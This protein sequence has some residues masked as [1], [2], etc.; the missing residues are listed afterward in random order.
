MTRQ[1]T[2]ITLSNATNRTPVTIEVPGAQKVDGETIPRRNYRC[3]GGLVSIPAPGVL[4]VW[5]VV[6]TSSTKYAD[7]K[8]TG[9]RRLLRVHE[10]IKTLK[11]QVEGKDCDIEKRWQYYELSPYQYSSFREHEV[12]AQR[13]GSGLRTLGM[14]TGDRVHLYAA[15]HPHW[16]LFAHGAAS[17]SLP[18]VTAYDTLGQEGLRHSLLQS[19]A[20]TIF[21]DPHL[22]NKLLELLQEVN[23]V[24]IIVYND[25]DAISCKADLEK[26]RADITKL[27]ERRPQIKIISFSELLRIGE[28]SPF[29]PTPPKAED[30]CCIMYTSGSTGTPKGV[31]LSHKNVVAAIAGADVVV[32]DYLGPGDGLLAYL[33]LA[34][35]LEFVFETA[36]M[37]WGGTLGYGHPKTISDS[38]VRNCNGDITEFKPTVL[39]GVPAVWESV[40]KDILAKVKIMNPVAKSVFWSAFHAKSFMIDHAKSLPLASLG[41]GLMDS[42]VFSKIQQ[43]TGGRLRF[44][45]NGGGPLSQDTQRFISMCIAPL[46]GGYGL[47]ETSGMG[48]LQDPLAWTDTALGELPGSVEIKLIDFPDAGYYSTNTPPQ[49]EICIRGDAVASGYLN[50][51]QETEESFRSGWFLTGD[52]GEFDA[53]GNLKIIDRKKNLIKTL[54]GEYIALEKLEAIYRSVPVVANVC[55]YV[56]QDRNKPVAV[57]TTNESALRD[58]AH[59][60]GIYNWTLEELSRD[61]TLK[62]T[63]IQM[64]HTYGKSGGLSGIELVEGVV[65]SAEE[66]TP[67]NGLMTPSHKLNRKRLW[68][69]YEDQINTV[70]TR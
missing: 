13:V 57:V 69:K 19:Q 67:Q 23:A 44:C 47:T 66:W 18:I 12:D 40:R 49:G 39:V 55:I 14:V 35:I 21:L 60:R 7:E 9:K 43:A 50:L 15:T 59:D 38:S 24:Q 65:I 32:G 27:K 2:L 26:V 31:L 3:K 54:N 70:Y 48:A 16:L 51:D 42:I 61:T 17:Q 62:D 10:E 64:M 1:N 30:L 63:L 33:P 5:D 25:D 36:C 53:I 68:E 41:T 22:L 34:H 37:F 58:L 11:G 4:T 46:C 56:A 20:K 29:E 6:R 45:M 52:I 8:A 28:G